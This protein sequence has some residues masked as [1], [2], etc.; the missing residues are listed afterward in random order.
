[1]TPS[2]KFAA[3]SAMFVLCAAC[4]PPADQQSEPGD[5]PSAQA[6]AVNA[7]SVV[8]VS[9][10]GGAEV[11]M[12]ASECLILNDGANGVVR[13]GDGAFELSWSDETGARVVWDTGAGLYNGPVH[14]AFQPPTIMFQGDFNATTVNG[15]ATCL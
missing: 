14:G 10:N 8:R 1:M 6:G 3:L 5:A 13:A 9:F 15:S 12:A 7:D 4:T 11:E 2:I